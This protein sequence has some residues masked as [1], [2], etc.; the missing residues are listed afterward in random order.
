[1]IP[2]ALWLTAY[3]VITSLF[4]AFFLKL[5]ADIV[6]KKTPQY[7]TAYVCSLSS[8]LT[9]EFLNFVAKYVVVFLDYGLST[10]LIAF[11]GYFTWIPISGAY[12]RHFLGTEFSKGCQIAFWQ[13]M[14]S[15]IALGLPVYLFYYGGRII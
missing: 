13:L 12:V 14:F 6:L 15:V 2:N 8:M 7:S 9:N 10:G 4:I 1:M 5:A 11:L 3:C